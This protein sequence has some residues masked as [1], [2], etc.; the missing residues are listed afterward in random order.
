ML[1]EV[2]FGLSVLVFL[3]GTHLLAYLTGYK[4]GVGEVSDKD[5]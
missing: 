3:A 1:T 5:E 4:R 2:L